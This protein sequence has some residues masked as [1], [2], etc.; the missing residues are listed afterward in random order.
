VNIPP[1]DNPRA[2]LTDLGYML[3][4]HIHERTGLKIKTSFFADVLRWRF[5]FKGSRTCVAILQ[6]DIEEKGQFVCLQIHRNRMS[7]IEKRFSIA[8]PSFMDEMVEM[9]IDEQEKEDE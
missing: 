1:E 4:H 8:D 3:A 2:D 5:T 7:P 6:L 9:I